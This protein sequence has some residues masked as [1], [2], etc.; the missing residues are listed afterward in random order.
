M[1]DAEA[2]AIWYANLRRLLEDVLRK[3]KRRVVHKKPSL[4]TKRDR[5][6]RKKEDKP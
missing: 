6:D 5:Q 2:D 4:P 1:T 3:G